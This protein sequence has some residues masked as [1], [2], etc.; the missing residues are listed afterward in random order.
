[1]GSRA[2]SLLAA[3]CVALS[4]VSG[5][6]LGRHL[7]AAFGRPPSLA[8]CPGAILPAR[9]IPGSFRRREQLHVVG[10]GV[11]TALDLVEEKRDDRLVVV[12]FN[13]FGA[14]AFAL[15]QEGTTTRVE[16]SLG[17]ALSVPPENVLR[18]LHRARFLAVP[19]APLSDGVHRT[20]R[21][22]VHVRELWKGGRLVRRTLARPG[23]APVVI[24]FSA[25][26]HTMPPVAHIHD[27]G[28][29]YEA[30]LTPVSEEPLGAPASSRSQSSRVRRSFPV[31]V[32]GSEPTTRKARGTL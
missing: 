6:A 17:P 15:V 25:G 29:G 31:T 24:D 28:C 7:A 26:G 1:M 10:D 12:A 14:K 11:D 16:S 18:D 8:A 19:G 32:V 21:A 3:A 23:A 2:T 13:A 22:G 27:T 5:C 30:T 9:E 4:G 20:I